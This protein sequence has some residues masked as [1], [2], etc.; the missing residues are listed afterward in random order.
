[1][2][3]SNLGSSANTQDFQD[4]YSTPEYDLYEEDDGDGIAHVKECEDEPT[5]ITYDTYIGEEVVLPKGNDM[6]SGTVMSRVKD[7]VGQPIGKAHKNPFLDTRVYNVEF[8]DGENAELGANIIAE[9][10]YAQCNIKHN[11]YRL[12]DHIVDQ[13]KDNM[14]VCKDNQNVTVNGKSYKQKMTRGKQ[15]CIE[16]KD[17]S[18]SLERLSDMTESYPVEVAEYAE[19]VGISDK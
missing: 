15:L 18:T 4:D 17:K 5:P 1:M 11:Q 7:F 10:M 14:V 12:M 9:C 6:V 3:C 16:W 19:A 2:I 13:R 8:S